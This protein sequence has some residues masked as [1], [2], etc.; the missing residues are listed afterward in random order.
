MPPNFSKNYWEDKPDPDFV[1]QQVLSLPSE[2]IVI[3][4]PSSTDLAVTLIR[5]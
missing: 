5:L 1:L 2:I 3:T 4:T